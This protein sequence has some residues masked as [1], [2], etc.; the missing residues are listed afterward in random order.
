MWLVGVPLVI[1]VCLIVSVFV[2]LCKCLWTQAYSV[3]LCVCEVLESCT[4]SRGEPHTHI[5][6]EHTHFHMYTQ[7][8]NASR[9]R[10]LFSSTNIKPC[11][12]SQKETSYVY[13]LLSKY[14]IRC[15]NLHKSEANLKYLH[16]YLERWMLWLSNV[17]HQTQNCLSI[18]PV[19]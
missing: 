15:C 16:H 9:G 18:I 8:L 7:T 4:S 2:C 6:A 11:V 3:C 1:T 10:N 12:L 13:T 19:I 5:H 14:T 17:F